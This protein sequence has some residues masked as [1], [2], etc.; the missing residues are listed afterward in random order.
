VQHNDRSAAKQ[1]N[2]ANERL[3]KIGGTRIEARRNEFRESE[4][5]KLMIAKGIHRSSDNSKEKTNA[6]KPAA[7]PKASRGPAVGAAQYKTKNARPKE[8]MKKNA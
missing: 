2:S 1:I 5:I 8:G 6:S 3:M 7:T 4:R